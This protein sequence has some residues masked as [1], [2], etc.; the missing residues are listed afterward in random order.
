MQGD[1]S[2]LNF[3]PHEHERGVEPP[4]EGVLRNVSG[5]LHQQGRVTHRRRPDRGRAARARLEGPGRR[6]TSS[7][8]ASARCRRR[9]PTAF[10]IDAAFVNGGDVHVHGAARAAP[11][12]MAS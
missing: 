7:A 12:P 10:R 2:V 6:A 4:A 1:F 3:D 11:G 9:S 5:V 8:P